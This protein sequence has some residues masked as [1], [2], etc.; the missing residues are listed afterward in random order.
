ME[1]LFAENLLP[2]ILMT[3]TALALMIGPAIADFNKT[4]VTNPLWP[5]HARFHIVWQVIT[6]SSIN[7]LML[8][9]LWKPMVEPYNLQLV[10]VALVQ[11]AILF[12]LF[13]TTALMPIFD[14][15]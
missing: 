3:M 11:A 7:L 5:P 1:E 8:F 15:T 13:V 14:G 2:R 6:N 12:P 9:L 4:H 10:L